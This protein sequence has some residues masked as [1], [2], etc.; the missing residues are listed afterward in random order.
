MDR[1]GAFWISFWFIVAVSI[2]SLVYMNS[3][4]DQAEIEAAKRWTPQEFQCVYGSFGS[5]EAR[6]SFCEKLPIRNNV[7]ASN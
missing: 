4:P 7:N 5:S 2:L 1:E 6:K 3:R